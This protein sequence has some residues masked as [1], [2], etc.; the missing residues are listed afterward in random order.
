MLS[1]SP[2]YRSFTRLLLEDFSNELG[3]CERGK[4]KCG[5]SKMKK[6]EAH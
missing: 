4:N 6:M 5:D 3:K 1:I 2:E